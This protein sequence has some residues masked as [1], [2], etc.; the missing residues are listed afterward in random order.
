MAIRNIFAICFDALAIFLMMK[1]MQYTL[2]IHFSTEGIYFFLIAVG[3]MHTVRESLQRNKG[4]I[5]PL[6]W[7]GPVGLGLGLGA[8]ALVTYP[9]ISMFHI[10]LLILVSFITT[11]LAHNVTMRMLKKS[12]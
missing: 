7:I 10:P 12:N 11:I 6:W 8:W 5:L 9:N 2:P 1:L 4:K 3:T